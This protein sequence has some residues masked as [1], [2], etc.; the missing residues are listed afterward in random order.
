[1]ELGDLLI[2]K[3]VADEGGIIR[4]A[5]KL[6]RVQSS[7]STRITQLES[8]IGTQLFHRDNRRLSL[9]PA[10]ERLLAYADRLLRL[11]EEARGAVSGS[12]PGGILRLGALESTA[13]SRLPQI[14]AT[15]HRAY[16][17]VSI[18]LTT[19]T[20]DG[21]TAAVAAR[22]LDAAFVAEKPSNREL[23]SAAFFSERLVII[24][25]LGHRAISRAQDTEGDSVIAFP[26]GCAYR[27]VLQR[28]LGAKR[29]STMPLLELSSY[30]AIFACVAAG[31]GI[32]VLPESVLATLQ[33][34]QVARHPLP[35]VFAQLITPLVW[36]TAERSLALCALQE[37]LRNVRPE[38]QRSL[39]A[40]NA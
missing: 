37:T 4:A 1:V 35:K 10:G 2:F 9:S 27:R 31:T 40:S 26:N 12:A 19:G 39:R 18:R 17:Q 32:A 6:H 24:S 36:R 21:L 30:H 20:N 34:E 23:S 11:S 25:S 33:H 14:L 7:V 15:Y 28:W 29:I 22:T 8:S 13:A 16:P 5:R 3:T 38:T